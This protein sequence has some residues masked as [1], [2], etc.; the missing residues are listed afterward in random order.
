MFLGGHMFLGETHM[1]RPPCG[2]RLS[3]VVSEG[4][5]EPPRPKIG[6]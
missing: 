5:F 6:H 1:K 3:Q 2:G 4:G